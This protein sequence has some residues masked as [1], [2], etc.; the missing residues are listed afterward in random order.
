MSR[1]YGGGAFSVDLSGMPKG[2]LFVRLLSGGKSVI[3]QI[4]KQ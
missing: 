1:V 4:V 2:T 3:K